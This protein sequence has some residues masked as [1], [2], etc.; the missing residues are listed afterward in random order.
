[1]PLTAALAER[2]TCPACN[3]RVALDPDGARCAACG[4]RYP[5]REGIPLLV[6]EEA[7]VL[8][9]DEIVL[10][11]NA[12]NRPRGRIERWVK[13]VVPSPSVNVTGPRL[14]QRF[15]ALT[16]EMSREP[17]ILRIGNGEDAVSFG[18]LPAANVVSSDLFLYSGTDVACDAHR[19][20]F[21]DATF[22]GVT[23]IAVLEHVADPQR[24]VAEIHRVLKPGGLVLAETPFMQQVHGGAF[25]FTRFTDLGHRRLFRRFEEIE[26]GACCGPGMA[27]AWAYRYFLVSL[28]GGPARTRQVVTAFAYLTSFWLRW[29]D[30]A[31]IARPES[32]D[33]ASGLYFLGRKS[34]ATLDDRALVREYRG[35]GAG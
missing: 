4:R 29:F 32:R 16:G 22:D 23:A 15:A 24:A 9:H 13:R 2:L 21:A 35:A 8:T 26:R 33:A 19:I 7:C 31:I 6:D 10:S 3:S 25:D 5:V 14:R 28:V 30:R 17:V 27:L 18:D 11:S 34:D 12:F 1:M 20:P